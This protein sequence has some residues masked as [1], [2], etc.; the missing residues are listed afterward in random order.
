MLTADTI[1]D[2]QIR[3]LRTFASG[4]TAV[5]FD[6]L[7]VEICDVALGWVVPPR[8]LN[9]HPAHDCV[10]GQRTTARARCAEIL[11]ARKEGK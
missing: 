11:N 8:C 1:T 9:A 7:T 6:S 4:A 2:D 5:L 10:A 3:E